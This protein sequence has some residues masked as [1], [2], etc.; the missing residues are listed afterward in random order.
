[1][2]DSAGL[3]VEESYVCKPRAV[4]QQFVKLL[5]LVFVRVRFGRKRKVRLFDKF[6]RFR[7][8]LLPG[9]RKQVLK[10]AMNEPFDFLV[11]LNRFDV[12]KVNEDEGQRG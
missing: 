3:G 10:V 1:L 11:A 5:S 6:E 12:L 4:S 7:A 2:Q 8:D 9:V